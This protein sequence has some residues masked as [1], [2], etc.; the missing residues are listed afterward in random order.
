M[1]NSL[2]NLKNKY[3]LNQQKKQ[4]QQNEVQQVQKP[5]QLTDNSSFI[6][7][8]EEE[9][10]STSQ[11]NSSSFEKIEFKV[12]SKEQLQ[13]IQVQKHKSGNSFLKTQLNSNLKN[14]SL[15]SLSISK[16]NSQQSQA[17]EDSSQGVAS[18]RWALTKH[19]STS[20]QAYNYAKK[21]F[22]S[23]QRQSQQHAN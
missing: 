13:L 18:K 11:D 4:Q 19:K 7:N 21:T 1:S 16:Q 6:N 22:S 8:P 14:K 17:G 2:S 9:E 3:Y 12:K 15:T 23:C 20:I 10:P 5:T